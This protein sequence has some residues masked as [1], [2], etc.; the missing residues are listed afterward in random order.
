MKAV[1]KMRKPED[2]ENFLAKVTYR[3]LSERIT[4]LISKTG[5][6]PNQVS[7]ISII[8]ALVSGV[9]FALGTWKYLVLAFIVLQ[10]TLLLDHIDG[11]LARYTNRCTDFGQW[12]D[13]ISN[14]VH[15]FFFF[16]GASIGVFRITNNETYLILGMIAIF[17]W[18]FS[19]YIS[20]TSKKLSISKKILFSVSKSEKIYLPLGL[21]GPNLI[22]LFALI[23]KV[24]WGLWFFSAV[25]SIWTIV[26]IYKVHKKW[27]KQKVE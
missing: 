25:G 14:K 12:V 22:G 9:F 7:F 8:T 13:A 4:P 23:N 26:K 15:K 2:K 19:A 24:D 18:F 11:N 1:E 17:T 20:E 10:L 3:I 21:I 16:L 27:K 5:I 6:T